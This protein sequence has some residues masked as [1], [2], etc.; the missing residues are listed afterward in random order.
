MPVC[1]HWFKVISFKRVPG[2]AWSLI[3]Q[4]V[5]GI[6]IVVGEIVRFTAIFYPFLQSSITDR[7]IHLC[8]FHLHPVLAFVLIVFL[9]DSFQVGFRIW[10]HIKTWLFRASPRP[11]YIVHRLAVLKLVLHYSARQAGTTFL[12]TAILLSPDLVIRKYP[13]RMMISIQRT[14]A[15]RRAL[16]PMQASLF[17]QVL[18]FCARRA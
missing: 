1:D 17:L 14:F 2:N 8:F 16:T 15:C 10:R 11:A 12:T 9:P 13:N 4:V 6:N 18:A 7:L 5:I 3:I